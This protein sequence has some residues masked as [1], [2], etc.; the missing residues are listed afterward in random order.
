MRSIFCP[1]VLQLLGYFLP[2]AQDEDR[3][4]RAENVVPSWTEL[5]RAWAR[6]GARGWAV[7]ALWAMGR[8]A[9]TGRSVDVPAKTREEVAGCL[10]TVTKAGCTLVCS[11]A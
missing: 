11:A 3:N 8:A 2:P 9:F 7:A 6:T 5:N 4:K 10:P 1:F